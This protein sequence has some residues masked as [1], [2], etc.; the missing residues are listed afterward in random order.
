M[1]HKTTIALA[2]ALV[3]GSAAFSAGAFARATGSGGGGLEGFR[4]DQFVDGLGDRTAY[5]GH[6]TSSRRLVLRGKVHANK[7]SHDKAPRIGQSYVANG[8]G[9]NVW[10]HWGNYYGPM[11]HAP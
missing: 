11:I 9:G 7:S 4:N 8:P 10:A 3:L 5:Q 2:I 6:G 1:M